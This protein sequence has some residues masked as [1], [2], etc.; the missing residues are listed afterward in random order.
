ME[1]YEQHVNY[2]TKFLSR[3]FFKKLMLVGLLL[4]VCVFS[5]FF[6]ANL[7]AK[8]IEIPKAMKETRTGQPKISNATS[9]VQSQRKKNSKSKY[10][11]ARYKT[12]GMSMKHLETKYINKSNNRCN[13]DRSQKETKYYGKDYGSDY[14]KTKYIMHKLCNE[15]GQRLSIKQR[16][17]LVKER[18]QT[19]LKENNLR[20]Y[21]SVEYRFN[22]E[23]WRSRSYD[24][25]ICLNCKVASTNT[26]RVIYVLDN[27]FTGDINNLTLPTVREYEK[28]CMD[29][30]Q[31]ILAE[32]HRMRVMMVREPLERLLSAY[33]DRRA[34]AKHII[35]DPS[36]SFKEYLQLI[37][38]E[39]TKTINRHLYPYFER[40]R[41][42]EMQYDFI[43]LHSHFHDDIKTL[44]QL[45]GASGKADI[46]KRNETG[47]T[48]ESSDKLLKLY[49]SKVPND[50]IHNLWEKY[51]KDYYIFG[52]PYPSHLMN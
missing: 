50:L 46:P 16:A 23:F 4:F 41:P 49:F 44:L 24:L 42:C 29:N 2:K 6:F 14:I 28:K 19:F 47:Y 21:P 40:C 45:I 32:K 9:N 51:Y 26:R 1:M 30:F 52:F 35:K 18:C 48:S 12:E 22:G 20:L 5:F 13:S 33:R 3:S 10:N 39:K 17:D 36:V 43:V 38:H 25:T 37:L 11:G 8:R 15:N 7:L 27:N 31:N 34:Y